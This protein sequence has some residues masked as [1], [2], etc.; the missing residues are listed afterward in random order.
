MRILCQF[1]HSWTEFRVSELRAAAE[2]ADVPLRIEA[3]DL[4]EEVH[5][6]VPFRRGQ[7]RC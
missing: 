2:A 1:V 4:A 3:A 7:W 5:Y 6:L